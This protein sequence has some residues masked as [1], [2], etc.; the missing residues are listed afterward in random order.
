MRSPALRR[1]SIVT[2]ILLFSVLGLTLP[3]A[4][5]QTRPGSAP[6]T[7]PATAPAGPRER[8]AARIEELAKRIE[9]RL[10][11]QRQ[12]ERADAA[13]ALQEEAASGGRALFTMAPTLANNQYQLRQL[14]IR[15]DLMVDQYGS[16]H[17]RYKAIVHQFETMREAYNRQL[18]AARSK[19]AA[20]L[21]A[22]R[23][24]AAAVRK[25]LEIAVS[26]E[27]AAKRELIDSATPVSAGGR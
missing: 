5:A 2:S 4:R 16:Q 20:E 10:E 25:K 3:I 12:A 11:F 14:E 21:D 26:N 9:E 7:T 18:E 22:A 15:R 8:L 17:P 13:L 19:A 6:A 24:D 27:T 23:A 1:R